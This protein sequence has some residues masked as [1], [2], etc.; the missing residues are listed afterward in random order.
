MV[1]TTSD[2]TNG[3]VLYRRLWAY[4]A[5]YWKIFLA[6]II[7]MLVVAATGPLFAALIKPL[8]NEGFVDKNMEAM[9]W[10]PFAIVGLFLLRGVFNFI[11]E[12]STSYLS[13]HLVQRLRE[14]MFAKILRLPAGFY[15]DNPSGRMISRVLNDVNQITDA[16]FNVIT[17]LA[18]DGVTVLGLLGWLLYLD[19]QLTLVT[20]VT[21]PVVA[22]C[23]RVVSV[24]LRR[25]SRENQQHLGQMTQVL[26]ENVEGIRVVKIYGGQD[27]ENQRFRDS[28]LSVRH[29]LVKQ[30]A[31]NSANTALTQL[32]VSIAL[33]LII[34]FAAVGA[35]NQTFSAGDFMSF[36]TAMIMMFDPIK[37]IT[38]IMQSLQRGMAAAESV[39]G[40]LDTPEETDHGT[41]RPQARVRG[42]IRFD[43]VSFRYPQA[44]KDSVRALNLDILPG[45]MVALVGASGCGKTTTVNLIPRFFEVGSGTISLDEIDVRDYAL[46]ALRGEM[47][48][49]S[50]DVVLF[51]D[52]I[53]RNVAYGECSDADESAIIAA[54]QAANAWQFVS[55]MPE[56]IHTL[57]G[58]NG[59]KLSGGQRQRLAIARALLKNAPVLMLDEATSALDTESEK[60]VQAALDK[61]MENRTTIV[62]A[63][64]LS[65]V[66]NA[67][68]IVV[69]H[70][71]QVVEIGTHQELL[72]RAGRYAALYAMQFGTSSQDD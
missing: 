53:A 9:R 11:N 26:G 52:T 51:N 28:A 14:T 36:L 46:D 22:A 67:D 72:A 58:E 68:K 39:F 8:I 65:T 40:F 56:G 59:A 33:A 57:I 61:L 6:S 23:I 38:G 60:L 70:E 63:H 43:N 66:E 31:A 29:N 7:A 24:R 34:Y 3:W 35:H 19:W 2:K 71:G 21:I 27:Y 42:H 41:F 18:K 37:R 54:L 25:L 45:E 10:I 15:H 55:A 5:D 16:G 13:G 12:Y 17:V 20:F 30:T 50:Q 32:M 4:L 48:L 44:E 47:S 64:R 62:I 49:V 69:M 1:D